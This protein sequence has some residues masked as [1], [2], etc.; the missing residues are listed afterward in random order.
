LSKNEFGKFLS[1]AA[2]SAGIEGNIT[3]HSIRK[4]CV[5]RLMDADI[6]TNYVDQLSGHKNLNSI[7]SYKT[8][9]R[10]HQRKMS[11]V[12]SRSST[13]HRPNNSDSVLQTTPNSHCITITSNRVMNYDAN[14][15]VNFQVSGL[16][17]FSGAS[18]GKIKGCTFNIQYVTSEQSTDS[19][20]P[21][22]SKKRRVLI[23]DDSDSD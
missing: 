18:I 19:N 9:S 21:T 6:P 12:L 3:N 23:S 20:Q 16:A 1:K 4:T 17:L 13:S 2:K 5:S 22:K 11:N 10:D 14:S 15:A 8:A 7:D